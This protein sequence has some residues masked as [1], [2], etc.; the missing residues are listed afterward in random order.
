MEIVMNILIS[1]F[2]FYL[3][4]IMDIP[5]IIYHLFHNKLYLYC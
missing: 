4:Y 2:M 1:F 3:A 5:H